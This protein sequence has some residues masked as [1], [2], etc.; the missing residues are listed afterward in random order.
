MVCQKFETFPMS[1]SRH[2]AELTSVSDK[3]LQIQRLEQS[4]IHRMKISVLV[5]ALKTFIVCFMKHQK[6]IILIKEAVRRP[7]CFH[8][9]MSS[10]YASGQRSLFSDGCDYSMVHFNAWRHIGSLVNLFDT[11]CPTIIQSNDKNLRMCCMK[12]VHC[13]KTSQVVIVLFVVNWIETYK[14][15]TKIIVYIE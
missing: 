15:V 13:Y 8:R 2:R 3:P 14:L 1:Y 4:I 5:H 7:S 10:L 9:A 11:V 6:Y 12:K